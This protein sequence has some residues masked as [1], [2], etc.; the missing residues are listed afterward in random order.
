VRC[1]SCQNENPPG[2]RFCNRCG[3]ELAAE[4]Q[5]TRAAPREYTPPHLRAAILRSRATVEGERKQ[6]TVLFADVKGST[7]LAESV[8]LEEWHGILDRLFQV[9]TQGVHRHEG[10]VNQYT[11]D[12]VMALFGAPIA[13]EDHARRA[14]HAA[15]ELRDELRRFT[16]HLR[17]ERGLDCAVRIGLNSGEVIVG[18]I[19]D[20]L[21]M[22]YTA[23]GA[24]VNLAA[25]M[26]QLAAPGQ[27]Y[28]T[29]RTADLASGFFRFR[30]LGPTRV[31]GLEP[32]VRVFELE[33]RGPMRTR[34]DLSRARGLS[35]LV[36]RD[37]EIALLEAALARLLEGS[38]GAVA[39]VGE[40]GVGK[41]RL[42]HEVAERCR[43][44]GIRVTQA[45]CPPHGRAL[46]LSVAL[47][48][49]RAY[50]G[51][52][53][54]ELDETARDK[55]AGR[56][57]R[58]APALGEEVPLLLQFLGIPDPARPAP[59][60]APEAVLPRLTETVKA[61]ERARGEREPMVMIV[62]DLHWIDAASESLLQALV[63]EA[64]STRTLAVVDYRPEYA[65][66][67]GVSA[68]SLAPLAGESADRLVG[69]LLGPA[70]AS[71]ELVALVR[72][73]AG[74]NPFFVEEIVLA[75]AAADHL[76]GSRGG[77][78]LVTPVEQIFIPAT[79]RD[80][81]ASRIDRLAEREKTLLQSASVI[82]KTFALDVL[83]SVASLA[84]GELR[85]ALAALAEVD[86]VVSGDEVGES[87]WSFKH[88]LTQEVAAASLLGERRRLLH[89]S[90]AA[91]LAAKHAERLDEHA[92]LVAYH[93]E[94][95][96]EALRAA[97]WHRRAASWVGA[98]DHP[99]A[100]RH[101]R[102]VRELV[103]ALPETDATVR[104]RRDASGA[105]LRVGLRIGLP[106]EERRVLMAEIRELNERLGEIDLATRAQLTAMPAAIRVMEGAGEESVGALEEALGM[107]RAA[108]DENVSIAVTALLAV[109]HLVTGRLADCLEVT[110]SFATR[111][112]ADL[113]AGTGI[114][115][116]NPYLLLTMM[117]ANALRER[118]HLAEARA[119]AERVAALARELDDGESLVVA[120]ASLIDNALERGELDEAPDFAR[121][122]LAVA[123]RL[124]SLFATSMALCSCGLVRA[125]SGDWH[126]A[127]AAFE[128]SLAL[129]QESR[130]G[131]LDE[132][133][134]LADL[135]QALAYCGERARAREL[136]D[137]AVA[138]AEERCVR[139]GAILAHR[140]RA[141]ILMREPEP[142]AL[143]EADASLRAAL[144]IA[145]AVG[146]RTSEAFVLVDLA[147]L[148]WRSN[149]PVRC[150][151]LLRAALR[152]LREI[153]A[154]GQ[155]GRVEEALSAI[156]RG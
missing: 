7:A 146:G 10:T 143:V 65:G 149:D 41:S 20:D 83:E 135:A 26:E 59:A 85:E 48:L 156:G 38:G 60:V 71:A 9:L 21:R 53:P 68:L 36:G 130:F 89:A 152:E 106:L 47:G 73:R 153:G 13:H 108:G 80:L 39:L 24:T 31:K 117:R 101:W 136:A 18:R 30:D 69:H 100:V 128:Q 45:S 122:A 22:D 81:L 84:P 62:E 111:P 104:L 19:G 112:P 79:V 76:E 82:G 99:E 64:A 140:V 67:P 52:A 98:R 113:R 11:G 138:L 119:I 57:S 66:L 34:F 35:V 116:T 70:G 78:T 118:G 58:L 14:C 16:E 129:L 33:G 92:A 123:E 147:G 142:G 151:D 90:A 6:V 88:P 134:R 107:A 141:E 23:Q 154:T 93:W 127:R 54:E 25:R 12:G 150:G 105:I 126:E 3:R 155:V 15:L 46:P 4:S 44:L 51:V 110:E 27:V 137:A 40:P 145:R 95:A 133:F 114:F 102:R 28:V 121:E 75:L 103:R 5:R 50:F 77:Y 91:A 139:L 86:L 63:A 56:I 49:L 132:P 97:E 131:M 17:V 96:G 109:A 74:G 115:T 144:G 43:Y 72:E 148:A 29:E 1:P 32:A 55:V 2:S 124:G 61:L 87:R 94:N 8:E 37:D 120:L 125:A 42:C